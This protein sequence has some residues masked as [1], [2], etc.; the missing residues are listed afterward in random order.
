MCPRSGTGVVWTASR[1]QD[2][3]QNALHRHWRRHLT[4]TFSWWSSLRGSCDWWCYHSPPSWRMQTFDAGCQSAAWQVWF[5]GAVFRPPA[6]RPQTSEHYWTAWVEV[7]LQSRT[8]V[9][10]TPSCPWGLVWC[11]CCHSWWKTGATLVDTVAEEEKAG[12]QWPRREEYSDR[13][14][15]QVMRPGMQQLAVRL[16]PESV[17]PRLDEPHHPIPCPP[18]RCQHPPHLPHRQSPASHPQAWMTPGSSFHAETSAWVVSP[19]PNPHNRLLFLSPLS[20]LR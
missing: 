15:S 4:L 14:V 3:G 5:C 13:S 9:G 16:W 1:C 10:M 7:P 17:P 11:C 19:S 18:A 2:F 12:N 20:L 8:L 6:W